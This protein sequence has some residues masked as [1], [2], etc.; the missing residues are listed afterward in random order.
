MGLLIFF[1]LKLV[2]YELDIIVEIDMYIVFDFLK[3]NSF[4]R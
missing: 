3:Y 1:H 2:L 4:F